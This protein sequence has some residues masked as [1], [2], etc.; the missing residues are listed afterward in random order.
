MSFA[1]EEKMMTYA[2]F[3]YGLHNTNTPM[4]AD[5]EENLNSSDLNG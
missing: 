3:F 1:E 5:E 2:T 4:L